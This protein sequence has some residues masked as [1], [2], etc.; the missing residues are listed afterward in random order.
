MATKSN[1]QTATKL[2]TQQ[3]GK[4]G[5]AVVLFGK[6]EEGKARAA[7]F[8]SEEAELAIK[9]AGSMKLRVLKITTPEMEVVAGQLPLGR[10]YAS[11][12]AF[13]P[14]GQDAFLSR[15]QE[16]ADPKAAP[17]LP[18]NWD[19]IDVGHLS[20]C[21]GSTHRRL[22]RSY[23]RGQRQRHADAEMAGL[24]QGTAGYSSSSGRRV[25]Q[26]ERLSAREGPGGYEP[27]SFHFSTKISRGS[28]HGDKG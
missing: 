3:N 1:T 27:G 10:I 20:R 18:K 25:A 5:P 21:P 11:G 24:S 9:A 26:A 15:L 13:V 23:R 16:L 12:L 4:A 14:E 17:G 2:E 28:R 8:R 7:R 22:V 19:A 6:D